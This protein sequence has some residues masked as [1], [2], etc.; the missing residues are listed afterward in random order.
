MRT[1]Q[2]L[3]F[4]LHI[5]VASPPSLLSTTTMPARVCPECSADAAWEQLDAGS[6][7]CTQCG[8]LQD[9]SETVLDTMPHW[10]NINLPQNLIAVQSRTLRSMRSDYALPGASTTEA[11]QARNTV[12]PPPLTTPDDTALT[13]T[14][15]DG[16][17]RLYYWP[18][19]GAQSLSL[20]L[21]CAISLQ[22]TRAR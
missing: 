11:Y 18:F 21:A 20:F 1:N 17:P 9:P 2:R 5:R 10:A 22:P 4:P 8:T 6:T 19:F 7:I 13:A 14:L 3:T 16:R 12:G 15:S